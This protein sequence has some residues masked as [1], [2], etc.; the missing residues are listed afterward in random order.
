[1]IA[2]SLLKQRFQIRIISVLEYNELKPGT[3]FILD[4][5]PYVVLEFNFLR[6]QMRKPVAQTKIKNLI[7]SK[8]AEKTFQQTDKFE[9]AEIEKRP[10]KYLYNNRGEF[11]FSEERDA[12][13]RFKLEENLIGGSADLMKPN[14]IV[15]S[16][17]FKNKIIGI[18]LPIK[19]DLRVIE[20]PPAIRGDTAQGGTKQVKLETGAIIN[21]PLFINEG[22]IVRVN[23]QTRE[24]VERA[25]KK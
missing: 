22:D 13:K 23:T 6:M 2:T 3:Y 14:S 19:V 7:T 11:W 4:G 10:I 16:I 15:E 21:V 8:V 17:E 1:M 24:Y 9:E 25:E 20:A 5:Q 18:N 12:S